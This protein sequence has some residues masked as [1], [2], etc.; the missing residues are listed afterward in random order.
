MCREG[1][2]FGL[3]KRCYYIPDKELIYCHNCGWSSKPFKWVKELSDLDDEDIQREVEAG[4]F[5]ALETFNFE[6]KIIKSNEESLPEDCV[7]LFDPIQ[8]VYYRKEDRIVK[9]LEYINERRLNVA[10]NK[11]DALYMSLKDHTHKNRLVIP[12]KDDKGKIVHYQSRKIFDWDDKPK[13]TSKLLSEKTICGLDKIDESLDALFFFEGPIDSFFIKNGVGVGGISEGNNLLTPR[14]QEQLERFKFFD[15]IW[16]L[17][18]QWLDN[19]SRKKTEI[20]LKQ[21][22][23]VFLWPE[24]Y[25]KLYKDLNEM[26]VKNK[27]NEISP[28][29]VKENSFQGKEA[30]LKYAMMSNRFI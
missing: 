26:C 2:S 19:T 18:S 29:F 11:P 15:K 22:Q 24:K 8:L 17:D 9:A 7:N 1:E 25:G 27:L 20:L 3:S 6:E 23:K 12:F 14:Q 30:V 28:K 21:N 4:E 13:Y 5:D 10:R 16:F